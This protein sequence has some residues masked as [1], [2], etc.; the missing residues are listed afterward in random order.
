MRVLVFQHADAAHP[1]RFTELWRR[2]EY[3][4]DVVRLN[5]GQPIP[6][7]AGYDLLVALGGPMDVWQE[8]EYPWLIEEKVAIRRWVSELERPFMGICFGHQILAD[9][10]GGKVAPMPGPAVGLA[11]INLTPSGLKD[12]M[13]AGFAVQF[14]AVQWHSVEVTA[15]P[16]G[17]EILA[18]NSSCAVQAFRY[19]RYAYGFQYNVELTS[20]TVAEWRTVPAYRADLEKVLGPEGAEDLGKTLNRKLGSFNAAAGRLDDNLAE[21][22]KSASRCT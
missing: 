20:D 17:S 9:A 3:V 10:L 18:Y 19:G 21:L 8:R 15:V 5:S 11:Q 22:L 6:D 2:R 12:P 14:E 16:S 13:F 7:L 1:G 4:C